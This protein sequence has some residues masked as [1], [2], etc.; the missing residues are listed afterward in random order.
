M[1]YDNDMRDVT[2]NYKKWGDKSVITNDDFA[3]V[4]GLIQR[5]YDE[6]GRIFEELLN[7]L[8]RDADI[9]SPW[10]NYCDK[11]VE[12]LER[13]NSGISGKIP[14]GFQGIELSDFYE[15]EKVAWQKCKTSRVDMTAET[16]VEIG[17][18][19]LEIFKKREED[20]KKARE[21]EKTIDEVVKATFG[22]V[23]DSARGVA[24]EAIGIGSS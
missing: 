4:D 24:A 21:D 9:Q 19:A 12:L 14:N 18:S 6:R 20:L 13:L 23:R 10:S 17:K 8:K 22:Q 2:E 3:Y 5:H 15:G 16:I 1:G 11:G 7:A